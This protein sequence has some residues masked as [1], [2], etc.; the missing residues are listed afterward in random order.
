MCWSS[1]RCATRRTAS[2]ADRQ[3]DLER[4]I[5]TVRKSLHGWTPPGAAAPARFTRSAMID[6]SPR[7]IWCQMEFAVAE[8]LPGLVTWRIPPGA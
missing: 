7:S 3:T 4:A 1:S 8:L 2:A 6:L 5:D